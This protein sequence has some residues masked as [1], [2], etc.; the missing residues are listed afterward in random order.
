MVHASVRAIIHSLKLV[1]YLPVQTHK[2]TITYTC[3]IGS[4]Q[5]KKSIEFDF[6]HEE[7]LR[8]KHTMDNVLIPTKPANCLGL[9]SAR[10]RNGIQIAFCW[11]ADD[12]EPPYAYWGY[13]LSNTPVN[14]ICRNIYM[15]MYMTLTN[16][17][18]SF[19]G[20]K[21]SSLF[22]VSRT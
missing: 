21:V 17:S 10:Q 15:Y 9:L 12:D 3:C 18:L 5:N 16:V 20:H 11:R 8:S 19:L 7:C 14:N 2:P 1:D 22:T 4:I 13:C 6:K